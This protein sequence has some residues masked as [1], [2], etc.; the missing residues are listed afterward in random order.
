MRL[1]TTISLLLMETQDPN[2]LDFEIFFHQ[3]KITHSPSIIDPQKGN[4]GDKRLIK[5][6]NP[7]RLNKDII[8]YE[9]IQRD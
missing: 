5:Y 3:W 7:H 9:G 6:N 8:P 1:E 4:R 2:I